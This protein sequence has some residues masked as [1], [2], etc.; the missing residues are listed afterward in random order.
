MFVFRYEIFMKLH[1]CHS[2]SHSMASKEDVAKIGKK[3][4]NM[5]ANGT[6]VSGIR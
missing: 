3:L 6:S 4:E 1:D 5:I 2:K